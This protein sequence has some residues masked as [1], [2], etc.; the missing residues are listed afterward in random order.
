MSR[1][2]DSRDML[3]VFDFAHV[4]FPKPLHTFAALTFGSGDMRERISLPPFGEIEGRR[5]RSSAIALVL[6]GQGRIN[7]DSDFMSRAT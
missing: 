1:E 6:I 7:A 2:E 4:F 3:Q 5:R